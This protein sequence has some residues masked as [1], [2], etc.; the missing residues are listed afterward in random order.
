MLGEISQSTTSLQAI[1]VASAILTASF[2]LKWLTRKVQN[3]NPPFI[4]TGAMH[5]IRIM[6]S[7]EKPFPHVLLEL[8]RKFGYKSFYLHLPFVKVFFTAD[9]EICKEFL[10]D[11]SAVKSGFYKSYKMLH[12]GGDDIF[13]SEGPFWMHSRKG[14]APAFTSAHIHRM[15]EVVVEKVKDFIDKRLDYFASNG[16]SFDIGPELLNLTLSII[17]KAA[18]EYDIMHGEESYLIEEFHSLEEIKKARVPFRWRFGR[19]IPAVRRGREA[20]KNILEFGKH[21]LDSYKKLDNPKKGTVIDLILNNTKYKNDKE[22]ASDVVILLF[23]GY[24]TTATTLWWILRDLA[25][26]PTEQIKLREAFKR[27]ETI[28]ERSNCLELNCI[29][30]EGMRLNPPVPIASGRTALKDLIIKGKDGERDMIVQRGSQLMYSPYLTF[31]NEDVYKDP[32]V[33]RPSRWIDPSEKAVNTLQSFSVGRRGCLGKRLAQ[34]EIRNVIAMICT[35]FEFRCEDKG[36]PTFT[37]LLK[38]SGC[39]ISVRRID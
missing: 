36:T 35:E 23:A 22:R 15:N 27:L 7:A 25:M 4:T 20:G 11:R 10:Y 34:A 9:F 12:D 31:R 26:N 5:G 17:C 30:K 38:P 6:T 2:M 33:Y 28:E 37:V 21:I 16:H 13:T 14:M 1:V 29:I 8:S 19:F 3:D 32:D 18:F 24:D 39:R